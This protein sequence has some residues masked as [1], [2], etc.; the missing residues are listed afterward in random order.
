MNC[1][2]QNI[3]YKQSWRDE[4]LKWICGFA[5]AHGGKLYIGI[6]DD[7]KIVGIQDAHRLS[8]EI[9]N[10]IAS[11]MGIVVDVNIL[12]KENKDYIEIIIPESYMPISLRGV[13][14]YRSG[15]TKQELNGIALQQFI[16]KKFGLSWDDTICNGA[17]IDDID[18]EAINYFIQKAVKAKRLSEESLA[19]SK[20]QI[21]TNLN[22]IT[23]K[24][25]IKNAAIILFGKNPS[26]F[27]TGAEFAIGRFGESDSDLIFQDLLEGNIITMCSR[28]IEL[29]KSKYLI[30]PIH[31]EGLQRIEPLEIPEDALREAIFNALVHKDYTGVHIQMKIFNDRIELWNSGVPNFPIEEIKTR[32]ISSPRNKLIAN[33]F[34][35]AGFIEH[36]GR[37]VEKI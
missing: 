4:Y 30:S 29:L 26:Q 24:S 1:E 34:Y 14:H 11:T 25:E 10:K 7:G 22:L 19:T 27:I 8:E 13:Y 15:S 9:P 3:E 37:G 36:W 21:L 28:I 17:G 12:K 32:H 31:Y 33:V 2:N 18:N 16:L 35:R 23:S 5:N 20:K 6:N